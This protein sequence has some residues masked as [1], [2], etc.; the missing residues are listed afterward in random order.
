MVSVAQ[1]CVSWVSGGGA[2]GLKFPNCCFAKAHC[3][4]SQAGGSLYVG[5]CLPWTEKNVSQ[6][7][8]GSRTLTR[9]WDEFLHS[10]PQYVFVV[11]ENVLM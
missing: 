9:L 6:R 3:S 5:C 10:S 8:E 4:W 1:V 7:R 2:P 11:E